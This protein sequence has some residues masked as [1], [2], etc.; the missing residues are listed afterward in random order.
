MRK[1]IR[2]KKA[3]RQK[4]PD[5]VLRLK[6][7]RADL[8]RRVH[9]A[10]EASHAALNRLPNHLIMFSLTNP[11]YRAQGRT[12]A[13]LRRLNKEYRAAGK[14]AGYFRLSS[15]H[16]RAIDTFHAC[17]LKMLTSQARTATGLAAQV[18]LLLSLVV[19]DGVP[20]D[21]DD[22]PAI[23]QSLLAGVRAARAG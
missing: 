14:A 16:R 12:A 2:T 18:D 10:A 20:I 17:E 1:A 23:R 22:I 5:P 7:R 21:E 19:N 6:A 11:E 15:A 4:A 9:S 8:E 3:G 13:E